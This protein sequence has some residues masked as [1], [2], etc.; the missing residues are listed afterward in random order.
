MLGFVFIWAWLDSFVLISSNEI[1]II[2]AIMVFLEILE[3]ALSGLAAKF[4]GA[5]KRS[6]FLA[7]IGGIA[8][9]IFLGSLFFVVGAVLGLFI[10]SY[11]GAYWGELQA[12]KTKADARRAA[13]GALM[14]S[15]AAKLIKSSMT[16]VIGI[17]MIKEL[18]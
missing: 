15:I 14:G 16:V 13:M 4:T 2:L 8:G 11:L 12:G 3:Y 9:T 18:I 5:E 10:G 1:L 7:I 6:A 17:W